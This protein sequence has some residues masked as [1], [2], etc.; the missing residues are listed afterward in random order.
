MSKSLI[1]K[2]LKF[3]CWQWHMLGTLCNQKDSKMVRSTLCDL[4]FALKQTVPT[5]SCCN[6]DYSFQS[7]DRSSVLRRGKKWRKV[8]RTGASLMYHLKFSFHFLVPIG[9]L[10]CAGL[11]VYFARIERTLRG[12]SATGPV[13]GTILSG[14]LMEYV[15][16][17]R[18]C[19]RRI[20]SLHSPIK[21]IFNKDTELG[22]SAK[23][24]L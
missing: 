21:T 11:P 3:V 9:M 15:W 13:W 14:C 17:Q 8:N 24:C 7:S 10:Q 5:L 1:P 6:K 22:S 23:R 19:W 20:P 12:R 16:C 2:S 18:L 4:L